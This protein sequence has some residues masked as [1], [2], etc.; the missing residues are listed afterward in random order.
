[1]SLEK[2][3]YF[4]YSPQRSTHKRLIV[5]YS[6]IGSC[7]KVKWKGFFETYYVVTKF[8]FADLHLSI[9]EV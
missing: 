5:H 8:T 2:Q 4:M 9:S 1:M 3:G 6:Q 7:V